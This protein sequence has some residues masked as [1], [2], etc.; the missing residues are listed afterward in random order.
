MG[1]PIRRPFSWW[2]LCW[3][4]LEGWHINPQ[5]LNWF[6]HY[7]AMLV[8]L[9]LLFIGFH[10]MGGPIRLPF[11]WWKLCWTVLGGWHI[12][13]QSLNWFCHYIAMLVELILLFIGFHIMG[14]PIRLPFAWWKLCWTVL[15]GW[16]INP[17][18]LNWFCHYIAM[19]VELIL[20]FIGFHIMGGP[21]RLPFAWWMLCWTAL[22]GWHIDP[23]SFLCGLDTFKAWPDDDDAGSELLIK[24]LNGK[25]VLFH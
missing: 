7:I 9:I 24:D 22:E 21:I 17:Q 13:P 10:I 4:A 6:C 25:K 3:T 23:Q 5:S 1:G 2:M 15:G 14:G 8:E 16:H 19:L 12:N 18:S 11:A 20:L